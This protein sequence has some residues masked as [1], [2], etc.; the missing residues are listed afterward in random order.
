MWRMLRLT[1][2]LIALP[3]LLTVSAFAQTI[4]FEGT[5]KGAIVLESGFFADY[6]DPSPKNFEQAMMISGDRIFLAR[7]GL[8]HN[9]VLSGTVNLEGRASA[10]GLEE[11]VLDT[12]TGAGG[13]VLYTLVGQINN[14]E[15]TGTMSSRR[16]GYSVKLKK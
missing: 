7:K 9:V 11:E 10:S 1:R 6:C 13:M 2:A 12:R 8:Q 5:Y 14:N 4:N 16:C 15:F 3:S